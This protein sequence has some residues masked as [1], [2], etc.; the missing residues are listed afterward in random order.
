MREEV[1][2]Q[3]KS[4]SELESLCAKNKSMIVLFWL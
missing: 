4:M 2:P 3:L 1:L